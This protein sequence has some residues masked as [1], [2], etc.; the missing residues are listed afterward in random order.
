M[1]LFL[2]RW[3]PQHR[4]QGELWTEP[5]DKGRGRGGGRGTSRGWGGA[6]A[7][8]KGWQSAASRCTC[9]LEAAEMRSAKRVRHCLALLVQRWAEH[10]LALLAFNYT[11]HAIERQQLKQ[12][13]RD[14]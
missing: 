6:G 11:R 9:E 12:R 4:A 10:C 13:L 3:P 2:H 5:Q 8:G 1:H 14:I 7:A